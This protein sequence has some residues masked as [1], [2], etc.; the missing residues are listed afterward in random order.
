MASGSE[1]H[2]A[3]FSDENIEGNAS[4]EWNEADEGYLK[5]LELQQMFVHLTRITRKES[6]PRLI[7]F[8]RSDWSTDEEYNALLGSFS[9]NENE[10]LGKCFLT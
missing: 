8:T 9:K 4:E 2:S 3:F 5:A 7:S 1:P 6:R 10:N